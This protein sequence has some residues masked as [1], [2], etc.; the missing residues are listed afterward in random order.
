MLG[1]LRIPI[2][3]VIDE[4]QNLAGLPVVETILS[5]ARK[6]GLHLIMAHQHTMQ[7]LE[8]LLQSVF[9][10]TGVKVVFQV[11]GHDVDKLSKL[12]PDFA[13]A[14]KKALSGLTIGQAI[15]KLTARPGEQRPQPV[16][17]T[18]DP[19]PKKHR[20]IEE[21]LKYLP[22]FTPPPESSGR[23]PAELLNPVLRY[24]PGDRLGPLEQLVLYRIYRLGGRKQAVQWTSVI[25][26]LGARRPQLDEAR[27][28]LA[29]RGCIEAWKDGNKWMVKYVK[30]LFTGLKQA[31]PSKE[32]RAI[33]RRAIIHYLGRGQYVCVA[34]QDPGL[35]KRPDLV[36]MPIDKTSWSLRYGEAVA[37][38]IESCNEIETH[39]KQVS[40][41]LVKDYELIK[42]GV[43]IQA[44]FW[45]TRKCRDKL[46]RIPEETAKQ[47][48][49][50]EQ[51]YR[52]HTVK[53]KPKKP[54]KQS[55]KPRKKPETTKTEKTHN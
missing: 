51:T 36:A 14:V 53:P 23:D 49:I 9:S 34:R 35:R 4:F 6:Y 45:T 28:S 8:V 40:R 1:R 24:L 37:V 16:I 18:M 26:G 54:H 21:A 46:A 33:A 29:A 47:H 31:A 27:D 5:E 19:P 15:V 20:C 7:L 39:P 32:G 38:E 25:A 11:G 43:F 2:F 22:A 12:D 42:Q 55:L 17:V 10:N 41:N 44:E 30:G 50:P 52:I 48:K 3:I 13:D